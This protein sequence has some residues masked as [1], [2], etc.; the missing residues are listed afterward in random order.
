MMMGGIFACSAISILFKSE[1]VYMSTIG[2]KIGTRYN[3]IVSHF[4]Q[5]PFGTVMPDLTILSLLP[6]VDRCLILERVAGECRVDA[7]V[8]IDKLSMAYLKAGWR[9]IAMQFLE[10]CRSRRIIGTDYYYMFVDKISGLAVHGTSQSYDDTLLKLPHY[11]FGGGE[12]AGYI[13]DLCEAY[14][15]SEVFAGV[16]FLNPLDMRDVAEFKNERMRFIE[17]L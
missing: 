11:E 7:I 4:K 2:D 8:W 13:R 14:R 16:D 12:L 10:A 5:H 9:D 17:Q 3:D 1:E 6:P 15:G